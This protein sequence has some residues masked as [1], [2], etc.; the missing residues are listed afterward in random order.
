MLVSLDMRNK[1]KKMVNQ[2][3]YKGAS[4]SSDQIASLVFHES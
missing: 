4:D 1:K 2:S 3:V